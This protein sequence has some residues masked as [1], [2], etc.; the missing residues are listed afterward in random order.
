MLKNC[1]YYWYLNYLLLNPGVRLV[2]GDGNA[3]LRKLNDL[4][5]DEITETGGHY[6]G[7]VQNE[8]VEQEK[9]TRTKKA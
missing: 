7:W 6:I 4:N 8:F 9:K 2:K 5:S 1:F 3:A